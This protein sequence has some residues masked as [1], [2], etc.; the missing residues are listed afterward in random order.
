MDQVLQ[1]I[2]IDVDTLNNTY[3]QSRNEIERNIFIEIMSNQFPKLSRQGIF[4]LALQ[5][6]KHDK[7]KEIS[8]NLFRTILHDELKRELFVNFDGLEINF[9]QRNLNKQDE[10]IERSSAF[11][12]LKSAKLPFLTE[13]INILLDK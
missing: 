3:F 10:Y 12:A 8:D 9:K 1:M 13:T 5:Y 11:K 7:Y 2:H 6:K 4:V